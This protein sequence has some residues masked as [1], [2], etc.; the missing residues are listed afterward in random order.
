MIGKSDLL[1][2]DKKSPIGKQ[3]IKQKNDTIN[4]SDNPPQA[5]VSTHS[6]ASNFPNSMTDFDAIYEGQELG[7]FTQKEIEKDMLFSVKNKKYMNGAKLLK[8]VIR[9]FEISNL[10]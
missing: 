6:S 10:K 5:P 4:V 1:P 8:K 3:N 2:K 7:L 9:K